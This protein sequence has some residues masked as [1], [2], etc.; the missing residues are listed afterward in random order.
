MKIVVS[1]IS[2]NSHE[3]D[4]DSVAT[5]GDVKKQA[6]LALHGKFY[7]SLST[8]RLVH[9]GHVLSD[10]SHSLARFGISSE[11]LLTLVTVP[12]TMLAAGFA[13]GNL[14]IL[15]TA[16]KEEKC[17]DCGGA[18]MNIAFNP[19]GQQIAA[20][21][22]TLTGFQIVVFD[23]ET[24]R[25]TRTG[26]SLDVNAG[27]VTF[28]PEGSLI[29]TSDAYRILVLEPDGRQRAISTGQRA[30]PSVRLAGGVC[31]TSIAW[32]IDNTLAVSTGSYN[33]SGGISVVCV[34]TS[35]VL[36]V[37]DA[38][39]AVRCVAWSPDGSRLAAAVGGGLRGDHGAVVVLSAGSVEH[40]WQLQTPS[41]E[42]AFNPDGSNVVAAI[43]QITSEATVIGSVQM[44]GLYAEMQLEQPF[45]ECAGGARS[46]DWSPDGELVVVGA[47]SGSLQVIK[48]STGM[49]ECRW[50]FDSAVQTAAWAPMN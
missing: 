39:R 21:V 26:H 47:N 27:V 13:D 25:P 17:W 11:A 16:T 20:A 22:M 33:A 28:S 6:V 38:W 31:A 40:N 44:F 30:L 49:E 12:A 5:V 43:G 32:S 36:W 34:D 37:W 35:Q 18:V 3:L 45:C 15:N 24:L 8:Y 7:R 4:V 41:N 19:S 2:G 10:D 42:V 14:R 9:K 48:A 1:T 29:A 50:D 46:V 23:L